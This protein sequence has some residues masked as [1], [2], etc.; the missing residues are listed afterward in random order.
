MYMG[1]R[2]C[3]ACWVNATS[4]AQTDMQASA[5]IRRAK[6]TTGLIVES[7]RPEWAI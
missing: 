6:V 4:G 2:V 3:E 7:K 1:S 5:R